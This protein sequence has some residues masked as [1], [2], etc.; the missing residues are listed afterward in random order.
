MPFFITIILEIKWL[1]GCFFKL[2]HFAWNAKVWMIDLPFAFMKQTLDLILKRR[3]FCLQNMGPLKAQT[4]NK[5]NSKMHMQWC[6]RDTQR[7]EHK[8]Q[9]SPGHSSTDGPLTRQDGRV[10]PGTS[11]E[12][13]TPPSGAGRA[14][15]CAPWACGTASTRNAH[16]APHPLWVWEARRRWYPRPPES[17]IVSL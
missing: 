16:L 14:A 4:S 17:L 1:I 5:Y 11:A 2:S 7:R 9:S 13:G 15:G 8:P 12:T 6:G 10:F 3:T